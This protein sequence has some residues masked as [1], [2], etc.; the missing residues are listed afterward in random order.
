MV[1]LFFV[2]LSRLVT[3]HNDEP[4]KV[5]IS[6][7]ASPTTSYQTDPETSFVQHTYP[8]LSRTW[9]EPI[10]LYG[11]GVVRLLQSDPIGARQSTKDR[12]RWGREQLGIDVVKVGKQAHC[13]DGYARW[14]LSSTPRS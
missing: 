13:L 12:K 2:P 5:L 10:P 1:L 7:R 6:A 11:S 3:S 4:I 8:T 14:N 9:P